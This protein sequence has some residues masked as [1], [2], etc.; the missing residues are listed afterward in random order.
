[1]TGTQDQTHGKIHPAHGGFHYPK[2]ELQRKNQP[3]HTWGLQKNIVGDG[4]NEN[5]FTVE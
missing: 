2:E 3:P 4:R 5:S 1:M